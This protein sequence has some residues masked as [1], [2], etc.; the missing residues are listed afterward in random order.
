MCSR[1]RSLQRLLGG[2]TLGVAVASAA[3][4]LSERLRLDERRTPDLRMADARSAKHSA[5]VSDVP[6]RG[7]D[8]HDRRR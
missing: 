5:D 1:R 7:T 2:L 6:H 4:L 8:D 3:A